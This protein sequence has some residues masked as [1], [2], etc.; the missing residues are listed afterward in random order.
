MDN[1][2]TTTIRQARHRATHQV[3]WMEAEI[4]FIATIVCPAPIE[5]GAAAEQ[6]G[7][8]TPPS[9]LL[10]A[11]FLLRLKHRRIDRRRSRRAHMRSAEGGTRN[12]TLTTAFL[13]KYQIK[14]PKDGFPCF[15]SKQFCSNGY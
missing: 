2:S 6:I 13:R 8:P 15:K 1:N 11:E 4:F 9:T 3:D 12:T 7:S 5:A 14:G 10:P